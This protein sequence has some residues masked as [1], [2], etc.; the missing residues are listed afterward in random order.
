MMGSKKISLNPYEHLESEQ[1]RMEK[2]RILVLIT[3]NAYVE[4]MAGIKWYQERENIS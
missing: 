4:S 2:K 1:A 3:G